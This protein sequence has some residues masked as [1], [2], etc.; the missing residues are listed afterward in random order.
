MLP[1]IQK[2]L[3]YMNSNLDPKLTLSD[4]ARSAKL[5]K[6]RTRNLFNAYMATSPGRYLTALSMEKARELLE[7][8]SLSIGEVRAR[9][10]IKDR[11]HFARG[12]KKTY[13]LTPSQHRAKSISPRDLSQND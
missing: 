11:S 10:G 6:S 5:S 12:F 9:V 3:D 7:T 4:L 8:T 13:G 1:K 2:I